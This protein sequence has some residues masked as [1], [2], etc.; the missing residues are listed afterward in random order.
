MANVI[1]NDADEELSA[2]DIHKK[3]KKIAPYC[4]WTK[5]SG[6]WEDIDGFGQDIMWNGFQNTARD[7]QVITSYIIRKYRESF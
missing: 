4:H 3:L 6:D 2:A 5:D 1:K 7:K